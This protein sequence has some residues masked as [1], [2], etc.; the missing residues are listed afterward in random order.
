MDTFNYSVTVNANICDRIELQVKNHTIKNKWDSKGTR[1]YVTP[2]INKTLI[3]QEIRLN[4]HEL[5]KFNDSMFRFNGTKVG[6]NSS[7]STGPFYPVD[8][9]WRNPSVRP[10]E[11]LYLY[12]SKFDYC[13]EVKSAKV[14]D[15][16]LRVYY[17]HKGEAVIADNTKSYTRGDR[18]NWKLICWNNTQP[19]VEEDEGDATYKFEFDYTDTRINETERSGPSIGIAIFK[20]ASLEPEIGTRE[21][22]FTYRVWVKAAK[23]DYLT[24]K[25]YDS[26]GDCVANHNKVEII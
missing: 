3:W 1:D 6:I 22:E 2:N 4:T 13:I 8:L 17:P 16:K 18:G 15:V 11:G 12:D 5:D 25:V 21:T 23:Q 26:K 24:L 10:N 9:S 19:F 7:T 14:I 20:D